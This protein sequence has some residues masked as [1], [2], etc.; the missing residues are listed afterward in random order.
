MESLGID[1]CTLLFTNSIVIRG[2]IPYMVKLDVYE[3]YPYGCDCV[4]ISSWH[5]VADCVNVFG[6]GLH[7]HFMCVPL[8]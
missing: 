4:I 6:G 7:P 3:L 8:V 5:L 1:C 2:R